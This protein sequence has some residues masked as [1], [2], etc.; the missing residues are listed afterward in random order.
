VIELSKQHHPDSQRFYDNSICPKVAAL[1]NSVRVEPL[2]TRQTAT[3]TS[4]PGVNSTAQTN[5]ATPQTGAP[6]PHARRPRRRIVERG[7]RTVALSDKAAEVPPQDAKPRAEL[8]KQLA[9]LTTET[10]DVLTLLAK[11]N[12]KRKG[13]VEKLV[14]K[15]QA[16]LSRVK[17]TLTHHSGDEMQRALYEL[18]QL[19]WQAAN[20]YEGHDEKTP[21]G[22]LARKANRLATRLDSLA[23]YAKHH[24]KA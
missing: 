23:D 4:Q 9:S 14:E 12:K 13:S 21:K 19:L 5:S 15:A 7:G 6:T 8:L 22:Q 11:L 18:A 3:V 17:V 20:V 24:V 1:F 10:N 2:S 16:Q